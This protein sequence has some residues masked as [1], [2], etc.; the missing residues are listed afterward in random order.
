MRY[1]TVRYRWQHLQLTHLCANKSTADKFAEAV[2]GFVSRS[3][4]RNPYLALNLEGV[5]GQH[6]TIEQG[7]LFVL[8]KHM[9]EG[10]IEPLTYISLEE[11]KTEATTAFKEATKI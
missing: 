4:Q 10:A 2:K 3:Y 8:G 1:Y 6:T 5:R 9:P 11:N 7:E